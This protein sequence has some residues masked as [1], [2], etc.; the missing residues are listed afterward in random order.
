M[1]IAALLCAGFVK[2]KKIAVYSQGTP[3]AGA[4]WYG[5]QL[6]LVSG[7]LRARAQHV[8]TRSRAEPRRVNFLIPVL[9]SHHTPEEE[10]EGAGES[11][12]TNRSVM[13]HS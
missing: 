2:K 3:P 11:E 6:I 10:V 9:S 4:T 12:R 1:V 13:V 8:V 5:P 7:A